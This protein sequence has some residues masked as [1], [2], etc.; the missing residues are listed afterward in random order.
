MINVSLQPFAKNLMT[1]YIGVLAYKQSVIH[2]QQKKELQDRSRIE[3][4]KQDVDIWTDMSFD[5]TV[6]MIDKRFKSSKNFIQSGGDTSSLTFKRSL[7]ENEKRLQYTAEKNM[8]KARTK[9]ETTV[10]SYNQKLNDQKMRASVKRI[11]LRKFV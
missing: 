2:N 3:R 7:S 11:D 5:L 1:A 6:Q 10:S 8:M 9:Y 4:A